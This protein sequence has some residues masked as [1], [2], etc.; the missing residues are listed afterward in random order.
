MSASPKS[1][2]EDPEK[3]AAAASTHGEDA[4]APIVSNEEYSPLYGL[5]FAG[6]MF[7]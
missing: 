7:L 2:T 5:Q 4:P 1:T 3:A 6:A